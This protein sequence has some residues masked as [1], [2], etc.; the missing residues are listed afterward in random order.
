MKYKKAQDILPQDLV[1]RLQDFADGVYLYIP[2]KEGNKKSWG[3]DSGTKNLLYE[4]NERIYQDF[5][6]GLTIKQLAHK[7]YLVDNSIRRIIKEYTRN[8]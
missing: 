5:K 6:N 8:I 7:Y 3:E 4:R 2:R 1:N